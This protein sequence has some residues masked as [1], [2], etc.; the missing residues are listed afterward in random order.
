MSQSDDVPNRGHVRTQRIRFENRLFDKTYVTDI[1]R[2]DVWKNPNWEERDENPPVS[3]RR[4]IRMARKARDSVAL[5][6]GYAWMVRE[7]SLQPDGGNWMWRVTFDAYSLEPVLGQTP[8]AD[9]DQ[10]AITI[11]VFMDGTTSQPVPVGE[12]RP[13]VIDR[14]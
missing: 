10:N 7:A 13:D 11:L 6:D 3:A 8:E 12:E 4:A 9:P 1:T 5:Q 2:H 14:H